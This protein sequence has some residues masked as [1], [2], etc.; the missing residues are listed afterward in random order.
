MKREAGAITLLVT[1][2]SSIIRFKIQ[3]SASLQ[4]P[5]LPAESTAA[6]CYAPL[7][8]WAKGTDTFPKIV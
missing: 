5:G 1:N 3:I 7:G 6:L 4:N 2:F 8:F